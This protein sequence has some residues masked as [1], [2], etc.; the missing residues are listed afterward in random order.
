MC[1][2]SVA[3]CPLVS[4]GEY[5]DGTDRQT[6]RCQTITIHFPIDAASVTVLNLC[7]CADLCQSQLETVVPRNNA[8]HVMIVSGKHHAQVS[9]HWLFY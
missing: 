9:F 4:H 3:C 1:A 6:D 2:C 8:T 7:T 5:A